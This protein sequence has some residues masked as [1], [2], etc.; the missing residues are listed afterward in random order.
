MSVRGDEMIDME[1][2]L[3][4]LDSYRNDN[5]K[6][7]YGGSVLVL[8]SENGEHKSTEFVNIRQ[9]MNW[10]ELSGLLYDR[11]ESQVICA[12]VEELINGKGSQIFY[13][14]GD[15]IFRIQSEKDTKVIQ[16]PAGDNNE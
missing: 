16:F 5:K 13:T 3:E 4:T 6:T 7:V 15:D 11:I 1:E 9:D 14:S 12:M 8:Y 2:F 10:L